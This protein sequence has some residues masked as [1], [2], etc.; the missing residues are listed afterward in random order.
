MN[1]KPCPFC[2]GRADT[3]S[4]PAIW[5]YCTIC[6]VGYEGELDECVT[7]WNRRD[8]GTVTAVEFQYRHYEVEE[9]AQGSFCL[10]DTLTGD[11]LTAGFFV[12]RHD[13]RVAANL[14]N[15]AGRKTLELYQEMARLKGEVE[16]L[17]GEVEELATNHQLLDDQRWERNRGEDL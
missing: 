12:S 3:T 6:G 15:N 13:A 9:V 5:V 1:L 10:Y 4:G 8:K 2:G 14:L 7:L 16:R 11:P 17:E